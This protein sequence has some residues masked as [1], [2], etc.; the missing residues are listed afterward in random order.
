VLFVNLGLSGLIGDWFVRVSVID[1]FVGP[2]VGTK[3]AFKFL[4]EPKEQSLLLFPCVPA[5]RAVETPRSLGFVFFGNHLVRLRFCSSGG[6]V[7][8]ALFR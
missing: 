5:N 6:G 3:S 2:S 8:G 4:K 1:F 7:P